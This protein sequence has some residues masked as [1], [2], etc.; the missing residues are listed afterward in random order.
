M[1]YPDHLEEESHSLFIDVYAQD[2]ATGTH[3]SNDIRDILRGKFP[4][5]GRIRPL[6]EVY[7]KTMATPSVIFTVDLEEVRWDR[8]R[9][10]AE[11]WLKHWFVVSA[12]L[13]DVYGDEDD[14]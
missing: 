1:G 14:S 4:S 8:G 3:L 5:I 7:D 11:D 13:T 10:F 2:D 9:S 12:T 6:C